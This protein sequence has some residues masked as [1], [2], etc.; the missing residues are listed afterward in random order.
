M[1]VVYLWWELTNHCWLQVAADSIDA[2]LEV[3]AGEV[4]DKLSKG[5]SIVPALRDT[6]SFIK[7]VISVYCSSIKRHCIFYKTGN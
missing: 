1:V 6:V 4:L 3:K 2:V 5:V 7:Q